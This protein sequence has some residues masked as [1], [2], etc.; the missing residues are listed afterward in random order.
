[1]EANEIIT[2]EPLVNPV[3]SELA[4]DEGQLSE[5]TRESII[6][7]P[8][9]AIAALLES[10]P[11][12][13]RLKVWELISADEQGD[14]LFEMH[15]DARRHLINDMDEAELR[16]MAARLSPQELVELN[17]LIPPKLYSRRLKLM[18]IK[19]Q[20]AVN[21]A[22]RFDEDQ[23]G[24]NIDSDFI[25]ISET[26]T[27]QQ[28]MR[29]LR[30]WQIPSNTDLLCLVNDEGLYAGS[31]QLTDL[32]NA[33]PQQAIAELKLEED[34]A[35]A[36]EM[37]MSEVADRNYQNHHA[38]MPVVDETG[39]LLGRITSQDILG[40]VQDDAE[41]AMLN[42]AGLSEDEDL[43]APVKRSAKR[44]AVWLGI[45]LFTALLASWTIGL[46]E[47]TLEQVVALAILMPIVA[48]M[49]GIAGSQTLTLAIRG[50]ALGHLSMSNAMLIFKKEIAVGLLNGVVW[51]VV[52]GAM[53]G[54]WFQQVAIGMVIG[55]AI[56]VNLI[57]AAISGVLIPLMLDK[58]KIDPALSGAVILTT[59]TDVVGF[60]AF[61]G[62]GSL[63]LV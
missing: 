30:Q 4:S 1:M 58:L 35:I 31:V 51:A 37:H 49:G 10:L 45:N 38:M 24:R 25:S 20:T 17:E 2:H 57:F 13:Q 11:A 32:F 26:L 28:V 33:H 12:E 48:S 6:A 3:L 53:A 56:L 41:A 16:S 34:P 44:R 54:F 19:E 8:S 14:V 55:A 46:F 61:L 18:S 23:V 42:Q 7:L 9:E 50:L 59:V 39:Q 27:S 43:F 21:T 15:D 60:F 22:M 36:A 52:I 5:E 62:L 63:F 47:A 29:L 40:W